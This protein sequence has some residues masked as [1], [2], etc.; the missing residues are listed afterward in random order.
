MIVCYLVSCKSKNQD[1]KVEESLFINFF[2]TKHHF[3]DIPL[4]N[5]V[6]SFDF[7][8]TNKGNRLLVI[9]HAKTSC[10]CTKVK[11]SKAPIQPG[12]TSFVRVIYDGTG[13]SPEYFNKSVDIYS[14]ASNDII[15]LH[16]DGNLK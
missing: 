2:E 15:K 10:H 6:D 4:N 1:Q 11:Y 14:N 12:D 5:P 13:R 16:I 7:I 3:N 9:L 8:F